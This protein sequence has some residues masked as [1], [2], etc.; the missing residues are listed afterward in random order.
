MD[1][2]TRFYYQWLQKKCSKFVDHFITINDSIQEYLNQ[3]Y[4]N[5]PP[6]VVVK[7]ATPYQQDL[8]NYDGRL[9]EKAKLEQ[10]VQIL[11]YQGGFARHRGLEALVL[12]AT[13][14]KDGWVVVMMGWGN[15]EDE[16][17][18]IAGRIDPE[19]EKI[20]FIPA[21][22][23]KELVYWT[24]GATLGIIPYE[25]I[26]LNHWYCSP[27]KLWEYPNAG[28]PAIVSPF[29]ELK[30]TVIEN[31]I[32]WLLG[33]LTPEAIAETVNNITEND[34]AIKTDACRKFASRDNWS[35]YE[36]R[37]LKL[38]HTLFSKNK[39]FAVVAN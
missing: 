34:L 6:A 8:P 14:L 33:D 5:L 24:Q 2:P 18:A 31:N 7:N 35:F 20:R 39:N 29:P 1:R 26:C 23:Q 28:V 11:L 37:L 13:H 30:K 3:K 15:L 32:G 4:P 17:K 22:A 25:N 38:Y 10:K 27:N 19:R 12:S 16:L 21:A 36:T 9:H